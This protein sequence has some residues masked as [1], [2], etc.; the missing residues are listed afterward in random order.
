M[1]ER[2]GSSVL[3]ATTACVALLCERRGLGQ[4]MLPLGV[5]GGHVNGSRARLP[6]AGIDGAPVL[7]RPSQIMG[8]R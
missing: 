5:V 8:Y 1:S 7:Q 4:R 2:R 3:L 6:N